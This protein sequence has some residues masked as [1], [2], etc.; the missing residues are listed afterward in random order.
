MKR[1]ADVVPIQILF[2]LKGPEVRLQ[3]KQPLALKKGEQ[4]RFSPRAGDVQLS[5]PSILKKLV[6]GSKLLIEDGYVELQVKET[7][8]DGVMCTATESCVLKPKKS[9]G[10]EWTDVDQPAITKEDQ[11][12][13]KFGVKSG[14]D[15][16][17]ISHVRT[18][19]DVLEAQTFAEGIPIIA[20][21]ENY[22]A[23]KNLKE[24][25][26]AADMVMVARGDLGISLP[27]WFVPL[28]QEHILKV[29]RQQGRFAIVA[30]QMMESMFAN[31]RPTRAEVND[32]YTAVGQGASGVMLSGETAI[33]KYP[34]ETIEWVNKII[35]VAE[36]KD[37][38]DLAHLESQLA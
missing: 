23:V 35:Q 22:Q 4:V 20:K 12:A 21:I 11:A 9:V 33:G 34:V 1:M 26:D 16:I 3:L 37:V 31:K 36:S 29:S 28:V 8:E 30:T 19:Q 6:E 14:A 38:I 17:A 5:N 2:D 7:F 32:V 24:I 18:K 10:L 27:L 13:I 15:Y 25:L